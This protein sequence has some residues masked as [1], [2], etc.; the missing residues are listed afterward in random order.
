TSRPAVVDEP[1]PPPPAVRAPAAPAAQLSPPAR[2]IQREALATPE[3]ASEPAPGGLDYGREIELPDSIPPSTRGRSAPTHQPVAAPAGGSSGKAQARRAA[4]DAPA[5]ARVPAS[6]A[7]TPAAR[8]EAPEA[9]GSAV[10][11]P[12][13]IPKGASREIVLRIVITTED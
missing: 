6:M 10:V 3:L 12:I 1:P 13:Q 8:T 7:R 5:P 9:N 2:A 4:D 11:V